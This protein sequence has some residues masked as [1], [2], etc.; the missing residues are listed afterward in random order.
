MLAELR[1]EL[2]SVDQAILVLERLAASGPRR[3]GRPPK[4]MSD[5]AS[6]AARKTFT[7]SPEVRAR[8][9]AAQRRRWA[10]RKKAA[11]VS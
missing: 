9:A 2:A 4:W 1:A 8:I 7:R 3:P 11:A 6:P 5:G 10:K